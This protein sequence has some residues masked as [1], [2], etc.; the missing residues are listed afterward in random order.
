[1]IRNWNDFHREL[2]DAGFSVFGSD[3]DVFGLIAFDWHNTDP[4]TPVRWFSG[5][6]DTDPW[7]WRMRVVEDC[8]DIAYGKVFFRKG[9]FITREWYPRFLAVRRPCISFYDAYDD[10]LISRNAKRVYDTLS[11]HGTLPS[12][13]VKFYSGFTSDEQSRFE[14]ALID[15]Q[16]GLYI[17]I[18]GQ[19]RK[20]NKRGE[21]YGWN[22]VVYCTTEQFWGEDVFDEA[23]KIESNEA[24]R[25]ITEQVLRLNPDA[26]RSQ[27]RKF[28]YG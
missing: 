12:H 8:N 24:E 14:K 15:L 7:E 4:N 25:M 3:R 13:L 20:R 23:D 16:M 22:S 2:L 28:I 5:D 1:M 19:A 9:G 18:C 10:G 27:L 26:D 21:E 6:P 11:E 17:T